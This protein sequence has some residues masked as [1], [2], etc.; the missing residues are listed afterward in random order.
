[1]QII[2]DKTNKEIEYKKALFFF[3]TIIP[4]NS[5]HKQTYQ[6]AIQKITRI[7]ITF[8]NPHENESVPAATETFCRLITSRII[9][10]RVPV[11]ALKNVQKSSYL[12][13]ISYH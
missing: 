2:T 6:K 3:L 7:T 5:N 13:P 9:N 12:P 4:K 8:L 10:D 1:M 11:A